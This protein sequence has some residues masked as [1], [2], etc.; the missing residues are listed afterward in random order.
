[1]SRSDVSKVCEALMG[2][3]T[4]GRIAVLRDA[5]AQEEAAEIID[6][7]ARRLEVAVRA[8]PNAGDPEITA[9]R[10]SRLYA[11]LENEIASRLL[12]LGKPKGWHDVG[13]LY[14]DDQNGPD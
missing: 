11:A 6:G 3:D 5:L 14:E 10:V 7:V 1:M 8:V 2:L 9:G 4:S 13:N 12:R